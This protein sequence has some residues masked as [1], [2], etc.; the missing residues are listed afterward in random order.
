VAVSKYRFATFVLIIALIV[1]AAGILIL[2]QVDLPD[3]VMNRSNCST[4]ASIHG[5][6]ASSLLGENLDRPSLSLVSS[7]L[8]RSFLVVKDAEVFA[9]WD[10]AVSLRC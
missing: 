6:I 10:K 8:S 9:A 3:F 5:K 4:I 7:G 1:C 2:P